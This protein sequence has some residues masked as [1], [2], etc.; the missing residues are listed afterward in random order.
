MNSRIDFSY[1]ARILIVD[2]TRPATSC[3]LDYAVSF[4][5]LLLPSWRSDVV[6]TPQFLLLFTSKICTIKCQE[7]NN[8]DTLDGP[9][10]VSVFA[11]GHAPLILVSGKG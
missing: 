11:K 7:L 2:A 5:G 9:L 10:S 8:Q 1:W 3:S 6:P 4:D